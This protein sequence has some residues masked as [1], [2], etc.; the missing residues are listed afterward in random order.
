MAEQYYTRFFFLLAVLGPKFIKRTNREFEMIALTKFEPCR[1]LSIQNTTGKS[2]KHA[3]EIICLTYFLTTDF[4][5]YPGQEYFLHTFQ[6]ILGLLGNNCFV[7]TR[8]KFILH[9]F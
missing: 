7:Y 8:A 9:I 4:G 3:F 5:D 2:L 6:H 1:I